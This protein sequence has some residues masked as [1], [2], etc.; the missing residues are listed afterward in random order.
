MSLCVLG[1]ISNLVFD[2]QLGTREPEGVLL[3]TQPVPVCCAP[4][5]QPLS[6]PCQW[7]RSGGMLW[8]R[9]LFCLHPL[10]MELL[11]PGYSPSSIFIA[12]LQFGK[13]G[14]F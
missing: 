1:V 11:L 8:I 10:P 12:I 6:V 14:D 5:L 13:D 3:P 4:W 2:Q 7:G 9:G